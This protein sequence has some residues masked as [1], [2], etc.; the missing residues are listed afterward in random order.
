MNIALCDD[1]PIFREI[2]EMQINEYKAKYNIH[3]NIAHFNSGEELIKSFNENMSFFNLFFLDYHM[4]K[5][6]GLD[7][8]LYIRRYDQKSGIVFVTS[9]T[10]LCDL[11]TVNPLRTLI[12][13]VRKEDVYK[14]LNHSLS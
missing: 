9:E 1:M 12:K 7:T 10:S 14:V 2:L 4:K 11:N 8:A 5:L 6:T 13:P 3:F